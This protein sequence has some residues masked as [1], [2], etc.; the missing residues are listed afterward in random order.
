M[1]ESSVDDL[2]QKFQLISVDLSA[3]ENIHI[4]WKININQTLIFFP[5]NNL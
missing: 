4:H 3:L 5:L 2:P 1:F